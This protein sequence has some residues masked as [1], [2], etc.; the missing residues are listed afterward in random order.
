MGFL[1]FLKK[2]EKK[3]EIRYVT[4]TQ[5]ED[6]LFF[7]NSYIPLNKHPDVLI[8]VDK[9]ADLVSN[10][11]IQLMENTGNGDVRIKNK[12][13]RKIDIEPYRYMTR[14]N[15]IY[16]I[17]KDLLLDGDGNSVVHVGTIQ[18]TELIGEL[19]PLNMRSVRFVDNP[20]DDGYKIEYGS[21]TLSPDEV[22]H[23]AMNPN[24]IRPHIGTGYRITLRDIADNLTQATKT[25]K[26]FMR[27][28]N[29]PS[30]VVSVSGDTE[31][32]TTEKGKTAIRNSYLSSAQA[33][34][35]WIIPAEMIKVEQVKPLTLKDIAINESVEID[36]KTIAGLI[37][38]PA[39]FL[40][41]DKFDKEEYNN[42][43]N[44]RI[45][46]ISLIISQTLTRDLVTS[47]N[48]Y[49]RLNPRSLYSYNITELV[50]AGTQMVQIAALRR[51]ELRDWVGMPPDED[52]NEIIVL[53]NYL[54]QKDLGNQKK[55]K[56]GE[57]DDE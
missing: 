8:A 39:F 55:L 49:F 42:F 29:I 33:G 57:N 20:N 28:K 11:T 48:K 5:M 56:G 14:K 21:V 43:V 36:K 22:I 7:D 38:V 35:P 2:R 23:F 12:L 4:P 50:S 31:E 24:P 9:I 15:W 45:L 37:G 10:M 26:S 51:N 1:N 19:M 3:T 44:T 25:K 6:L 53:E 34:D 18:D 32:L 40:G 30:L 41:V 52:M 54:P 47:E 46:S 13:A 27:N 17:V 16:K